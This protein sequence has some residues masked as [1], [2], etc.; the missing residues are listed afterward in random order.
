MLVK[1][2]TN[3]DVIT[4]MFNDELPYSFE[5]LAVTGAAIEFWGIVDGMDKTDDE[6]LA[7]ITEAQQMGRPVI[8]AET[9]ISS[10]AKGKVVRTLNALHTFED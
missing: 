4:E 7:V 9:T 1:P 2:D 10:G 5:E 8:T 3:G 6:K